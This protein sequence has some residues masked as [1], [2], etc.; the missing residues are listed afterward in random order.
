MA[1]N[2][3]INTNPSGSSHGE[4]LVAKRLTLLVS[5]TFEN[6][7]FSRNLSFLNT[8]QVQFDVTFIGSF[9]YNGIVW[10]P[11]ENFIKYWR[12]KVSSFIGWVKMAS[13]V[14]RTKITLCVGVAKIASHVAWLKM[15]LHVGQVK[16]VSYALTEWKLHQVFAKWKWNCLLAE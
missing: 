13:Y 11:K 12:M 14:G 2:G 16:I 9:T 5:T 3:K 1:T 15:E 7:K 8:S 6:M 4:Q 10:W